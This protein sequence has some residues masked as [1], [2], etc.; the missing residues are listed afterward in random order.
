[1]IIC[2]PNPIPELGMTEP[3]AEPVCD[4]VI[5]S[6]LSAAAPRTIQ[7][8]QPPRIPVLLGKEN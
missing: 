4:E 5:A 7:Q 2:A 6:G 8:R 1:M 3:V